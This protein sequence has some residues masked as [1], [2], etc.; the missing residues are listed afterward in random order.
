MAKSHDRAG[1]TA[2]LSYQVSK[3]ADPS[4]PLDPGSEP[5]GKT[6]YVIDEIYESTAGIADHWQKAMS[7]W[8]DFQSFVAWAQNCEVTSQHSGDVVNS[9]W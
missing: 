2:L 4:N 9:L 8:D 1:E 5:T 3:G 6:V 7:S